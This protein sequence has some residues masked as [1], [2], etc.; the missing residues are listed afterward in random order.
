MSWNRNPAETDPLLLRSSR[1]DFPSSIE[2]SVVDGG[3]RDGYAES[4]NWPGLVWIA[5]IGLAIAAV[6][7][8]FYISQ[9]I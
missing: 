3:V 2:R 5:M 6:I 7:V 4:P 1:D 9:H 8:A